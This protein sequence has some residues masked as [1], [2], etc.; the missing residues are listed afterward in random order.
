M[1]QTRLSVY[2]LAPDMYALLRKVYLMS[3]LYD[4]MDCLIPVLEEIKDL[5]DKAGP[6]STEG[7]EV[8]DD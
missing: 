8:E 3:Q 6:S 1:T 5:L 7:V 4:S 2:R